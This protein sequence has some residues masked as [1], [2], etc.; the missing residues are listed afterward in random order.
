MK[1]CDLFTRVVITAKPEESLK[2]VALRMQE[3]NVGAVVIVQG[4][5][6]VGMVTDRDLALAL[7]ADGVPPQEQVQKVMKRRVLAIPEDTG[8][9]TATKYM[10]ECQVRRLPIVDREDRLVG[11]VT[12]DDLVPCLG[13]ELWNLVEGIKLEMEVK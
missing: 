8:V 13:G 10:R 5:R 7:G 3:H 12:L 6:P 11:I 2:A 9:F 1:L 4:D